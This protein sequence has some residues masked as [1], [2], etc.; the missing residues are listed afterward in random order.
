MTDTVHS[1]DK[2]ALLRSVLQALA[3]EDSGKDELLRSLL[4]VLA[5]RGIARRWADSGTPYSD[6]DGECTAAASHAELADQF[7]RYLHANP[8]IRLSVRTFLAHLSAAANVRPE[9]VPR[10]QQILMPLGTRI[11]RWVPTFLVIDG[12]LGRFLRAPDSPLNELL[13]RQHSTYPALAQVRD[14]FKHDLFRRVRNGVGHWAFAWE[15]SGDGERLVCFDWKS[16]VRT[17]E[18]SLLEAEALH[19]VSLSVIECLDRRIFRLQN[20]L[21]ANTE[22]GLPADAQKD[23]RG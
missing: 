2:D 13:Q 23:A 22:P 9:L 14:T 8:I 1:P 15:H 16:G 20:T 3:T 10:P 6:L 4:Q 21:A 19:V 11:A 5:A 17:A 12:P 7:R 18:V